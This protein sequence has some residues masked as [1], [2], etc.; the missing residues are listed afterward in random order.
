[1]TAA[2]VLI[3]WVYGSRLPWYVRAVAVLDV[4]M[5]LPNLLRDAIRIGIFVWCYIGSQF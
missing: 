5:I 3:A 2:A 4:A 1:M